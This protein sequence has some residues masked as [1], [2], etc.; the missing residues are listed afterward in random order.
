M[1]MGVRYYFDILD[2]RRVTADTI[3]MK[4]SDDATAIAE[5]RKS[6]AI[7]ASDMAQSM[8]RAHVTVAVRSE[9]GEIARLNLKLEMIVSPTEPSS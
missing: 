3:G 4:F 7:W 6:L 2:G 8:D 5:A 9:V 1:R